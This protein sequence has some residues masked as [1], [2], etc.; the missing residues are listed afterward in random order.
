MMK[1]ANLVVAAFLLIV[2]AALAQH[3]DYAPFGHYTE[4]VAE[5][6]KQPRIMPTDIVM[7]GD[8]HTE[9][10]GDWN[11][12]LPGCGNIVNRGIA[13]DDAIGIGHRLKQI[14]PY[15]PKAIVLECGINDLS[16]A[17]TPQQVAANIAEVM[18]SIMRQCPKTRLYVVG[19]FPINMDVKRWKSLDGK[20]N[21]VAELNKLIRAECRT[22]KVV[23][24]DV[25]D[26]LRYQGS[27]KLRREY[28]KDGLHLTEKG[29]EVWCKAMKPYLI[30][31]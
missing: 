9:F 6:E 17:L 31:K 24:I 25:F 28:C 11:K 13:G 29:Y 3:I 15:K 1:K 8:S 22:R 2:G 7:L 26:K 21:Q 18:D 10:G 5:F 20:T 30:G 4:R 19:V 14:C 16:H 23:Y 27:L 12:R